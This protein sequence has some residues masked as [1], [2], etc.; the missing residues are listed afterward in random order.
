MELNKIHKIDSL[1]GL[2]KMQDESI[3]LILTD[4]P[5]NIT[6]NEWD[7]FEETDF[8]LFTE[9]WI[10]ECYRILRGGA[11]L[12][13]WS[14]QKLYLLEK[15]NIKFNRKRMIIWNM[16]NAPIHNQDGLIFTWQPIILFEKDKIK[17]IN[18][19]GSYISADV[20]IHNFKEKERL[21]HPT[22]KPLELIKQLIEKYTNEGDNVLDCFIGS[23]TTAVACKILKRNFIGFELEN[24]YIRI[25]EKRLNET[26]ENIKISDFLEKGG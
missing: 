15:L 19:G 14:Q 25:A 16:P 13:F 12:M 5:Y 6:E 23:G 10:N 20:L 1:L 26:S 4:P 2:I 17:T 7:K 9:L 8:L 24:E 11:M 3:D 21:G 22:I 18:N